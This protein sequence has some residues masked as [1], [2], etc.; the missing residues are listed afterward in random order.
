MMQTIIKVPYYNISIR[1]DELSINPTVPHLDELT[2][3]IDELYRI[4]R[5]Y[6]GYDK[7]EEEIIS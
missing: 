5:D 3:S 6:K 4:I 7:D 2:I 1:E